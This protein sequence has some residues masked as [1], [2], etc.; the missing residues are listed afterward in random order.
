MSHSNTIRRGTT[1]R[2]RCASRIGSP[3]VRRL[4]RSV[5]RR[6]I[7]SPWRS[8]WARRVRRTRRR[9]P[10]PRHQ[11]VELRELVGRDRVEAL[12]TAAAPRRWPAWGPRSLLRRLSLDRWAAAGAEFDPL[13][14]RAGAADRSS[15]CGA[16]MLVAG[17]RDDVGATW[18]DGPRLRRR[19]AENA[20]E[21][22]VESPYLGRV[23]DEHS[24]GRPVQ[25][26]AR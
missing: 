15:R 14:P 21:H 11:P 8:R 5:R 20:R 22:A 25:T 7:R 10:Q 19:R 4:P 18:G 2:R 24:A 26:P 23:G 17:H 9:D 12:A 1:R 3:A 16:C 13:E 6:S